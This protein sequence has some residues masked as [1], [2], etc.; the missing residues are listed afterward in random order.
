MDCKSLTLQCPE[1]EHNQ[2]FLH[3]C[4]L[5]FIPDRN[6][7][8]QCRSY[9]SAC[10]GLFGLRKGQHCLWLLMLI[11]YQHT[12]TGIHY[13]LQGTLLMI[14][15]S[16]G[17]CAECVVYSQLASACCACGACLFI[18]TLVLWPNSLAKLCSITICM[19]YIHFTS[20]CAGYPSNTRTM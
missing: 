17:F 19:T 12:S 2:A 8:G 4:G 3:W 20:S 9:R 13:I 1:S 15:Q 16:I 6:R 14:S 11:A 7:V 5:L 18:G 10:L